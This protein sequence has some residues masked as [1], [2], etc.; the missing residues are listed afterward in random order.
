MTARQ[1]QAAL[2]IHGGKLR[3]RSKVPEWALPIRT[4]QVWVPR[5]VAASPPAQGGEYDSDSDLPP[6]L[7]DSDSSED[8]GTGAK[9]GG[10]DK[11]NGQPASGEGSGE[12]R[13]KNEG[14]A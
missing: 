4:A 9:D 13:P 14:R 6:L 3:L 12:G 7:S 10:E 2:R 5:A 11:Q 1:V 8:D